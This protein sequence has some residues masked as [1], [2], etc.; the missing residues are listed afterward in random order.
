MG[1]S[2]I[3]NGNQNL[4]DWNQFLF[5]KRF[6]VNNKHIFSSEKLI[7]SHDYKVPRNDSNKKTWICSSLNK[8]T[9]EKLYLNF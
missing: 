5:K 6:A 7:N 2:E 1:I 9:E 4:S 3:W 8:C